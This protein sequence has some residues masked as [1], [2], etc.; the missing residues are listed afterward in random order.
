MK[1]A[2]ELSKKG[3]GTVNPNPLVGAVI[4]NNGNIIGEGFHEYFGGPHA[5]INAINNVKGEL[6]NTS[7]YVTLEPCSHFGKTPSCAEEIVRR[8]FARVVVGCID[9]NPLVAG[10]GIE[11]IRNADIEVKTG[12]LEDE[13]KEL[14]EV[15]FKFITKKLPFVVLKTAMSLDGKIATKTGNSKWISSEQSRTIVHELRNR[16]SGIMAGINTVINDDPLL[17]I[18]NITGK[19]KNPVRIIIDS[20]ARIPL[21][22]KVLNTPEISQT[23]VAV[24]EKAPVKKIDQIKQLGNDVII[25]KQKNQKIDLSNL[26]QELA[27]RNIDSI[28]LEGGGTLNY[29]ALQNNIVDKIIAFIA[30]QIIGGKNALTPVEGEGISDLNQAI[31]L[32]NIKIKQLNQDVMIEGYLEVGSQVFEV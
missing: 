3:Y 31:K 4:V 26:M 10:K 2:F 32:N 28:L 30:P 13:I 6:K 24:T 29:E 17:N 27:N 20:Q 25:C 23:I 22:A 21:K 12:V 16:Y 5:E 9:P 7:I 11:I 15:F 8:K 19:T 14:N 1:R 18:R